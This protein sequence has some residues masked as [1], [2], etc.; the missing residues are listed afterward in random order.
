M[1]TPQIAPATP[2]AA[3][4]PVAIPSIAATPVA[5]APEAGDIEIETEEDADDDAAATVVAS[6][7]VRQ[8]ALR[9]TKPAVDPLIEALSD[10]F[11]DSADDLPPPRARER[12]TAGQLLEALPPPQVTVPRG[13]DAPPRGNSKSGPD[14][15]QLTLPHESSA[16]AREVAR[17]EANDHTQRRTAQRGQPRRAVYAGAVVAAAVL[18]GF[19]LAQLVDRGETA[20][21]KQ[22]ADGKSET[23]AVGA[24]EAGRTDGSDRPLAAAPNLAP[25]GVPVVSVQ[26]VTGSAPALV[27]GAQPAVVRV[28]PASAAVQT[29]AQ[30]AIVQ[31]IVAPSDPAVRVDPPPAVVLREADSEEAAPSR[32]SSSRER[33]STSR[34]S[35]PAAN[36][37]ALWAKA[38]DE[39]RDL[40]TAKRYKQAAD[41]YARAA[42]YNPSHAGTWAGLGASRANA[43]DARG[44][45][46]AYQKAIKISPTTSGF[47]A[48]LGR[49][50]VAAGDT[51]RAKAAYKKALSID[52]NNAAAKAAL[53]GL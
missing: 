29:S 13:S 27:T 30:P 3:A 17:Q 16:V 10:D 21:A 43:N 18:L 26:P 49:A 52:P 2:V 37:D 44:A 32:R 47:H 38:R 14:S 34:A 11:D 40:Y 24:S 51:V 12:A 48:A 1:V 36:N 39:A 31:P 9:T 35:A 42:K 28:E 20:A 7:P 23:S 4:N 50:Y 5:A 46:Q 6:R 22:P 15:G 33:R 41:A 19:A 53:A 45:I 8:A 25:T